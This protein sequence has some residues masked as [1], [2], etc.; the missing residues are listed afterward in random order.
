MY[1]RKSRA[2]AACAC[3]Q[4]AAPAIR[5]LPGVWCSTP[6]SLPHIAGEHGCHHGQ[7]CSS[8]EHSQQTARH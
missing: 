1:L 3:V 4:V 6:A 5:L 7:L 2:S 8:Q